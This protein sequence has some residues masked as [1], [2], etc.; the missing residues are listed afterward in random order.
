MDTTRPYNWS[1]STVTGI[2]NN[3]VYLGH[4]QGLRNTSISYKNKKHILRPESEQIL[5][6]NTHEALV[7]QERWDIVQTVHQ[8]KK[9]TP[10]QMDEPNMFSGLGT[11]SSATPS[12]SAGRATA[13]RTTS[14]RWI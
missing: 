14:G 2:L 7:S 8:H 3:K 4:M 13:P 5:V 11:I 10:K 9:R 6:E 1:S 12:A